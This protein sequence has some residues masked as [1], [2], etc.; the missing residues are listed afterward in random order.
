MSLSQIYCDPAKVSKEDKDALLGSLSQLDSKLFDQVQEA[1]NFS[2]NASQSEVSQLPS[3]SFFSLSKDDSSYINETKQRE[4]SK[5]GLD[6]ISKGQVAVL[7]MAGGQGSRLGSSDPKGTYVI[8]IPSKSSLFELQAKRILKLQELANGVIHWYVMASGPTREKTE[9]FFKEKNFFGLKPE[10][11][12]FFNQGTL[13]AFTKDGKQIYRSA[14]NTLVESPDGNGGLYK[15]IHDSNLLEDFKKRGIMH[16]HMYAVDNCLA[17]VADPLFIG[18]AVENNFDLATKV[19]RKNEPT[20]SVGL[21]ISKQGKPSV[22]EYSEIS[23]ELACKKDENNQELLYLRAANIVQH[24]YSVDLLEKMVPVW[25]SSREYLPYHIAKKK[26]P[27]LTLEDEYVKPTAVNGIKLE[28]FIFDIFPSIELSKFGSLEV[29]R[30][31]EFSP[32]K[33]GPGTKSDNPE[34]SAS[35]LKTLHT[36]WILANGGEIEKD[37]KVEIDALLSYGGEG[38]EGV[39]GKVFKEDE[40]ITSF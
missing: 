32:L 35:A 18:F 1:I 23:D 37:G 13:P 20:E 31:E 8:D 22:I 26:I 14:K 2:S 16:I 3:S 34:T 25:I 36:S 7:L 40:Y 39:K 15:A 27:H 19:V 21:I 30:N 9:A 5:L 38:L 33:N 10:N 4:L 24:Y 6:L 11:V 28:Q 17:K 12:T 29:Q